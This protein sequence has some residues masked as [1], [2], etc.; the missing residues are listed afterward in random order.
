MNPKTVIWIGLL[1]MS[2]LGSWLGALAAHGNWLSWQ[3]IVGSFVGAFAG[4]YIG[5]QIN[6]YF[7]N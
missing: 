7:G 5:Y 2:T 3:S 1:I 4:I 6:Q